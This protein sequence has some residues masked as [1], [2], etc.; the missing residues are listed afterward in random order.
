MYEDPEALE[1]LELELEIN[2]IE[3]EMKHVDSDH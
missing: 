3:M 2:D 1:Q